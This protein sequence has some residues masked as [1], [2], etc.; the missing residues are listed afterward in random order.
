MIHVDAINASDWVTKYGEPGMSFKT[1][2]GIYWDDD[3]HCENTIRCGA[4]RGEV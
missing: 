2:A 4:R 3:K 1:A